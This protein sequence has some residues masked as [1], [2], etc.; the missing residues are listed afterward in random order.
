M[1]RP[2]NRKYVVKFSR[3]SAQ[4]VVFGLDSPRSARECPPDTRALTGS[5]PCARLT[6]KNT[7]SAEGVSHTMVPPAGVAAPRFARCS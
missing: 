3:P 1:H 4:A 7:P 5:T 2:Q 6:T